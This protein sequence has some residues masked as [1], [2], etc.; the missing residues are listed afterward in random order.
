MIV[1]QRFYLIFQQLSLD[2]LEELRTIEPKRSETLLTV[3]QKIFS[4]DAQVEDCDFQYV[5]KKITE[6]RNK[7]KPSSVVSL[8]D[9]KYDLVNKMYSAQALVLKAKIEEERATFKN[10]TGHQIIASLTKLLSF[11]EPESRVDKTIEI[12]KEIILNIS[13]LKTLGFYEHDGE[14]FK[15]KLTNEELALFNHL[16]SECEKLQRSNNDQEVHELIVQLHHCMQCVEIGFNPQVIL[17][18]KLPKKINAFLFQQHAIY[19]I[20][21]FHSHVKYKLEEGLYVPYFPQEKRDASG[22]ITLMKMSEIANEA[23]KSNGNQWNILE[24]GFNRNCFFWEKLEPIAQMNKWMGGYALEL[25][26]YIPHNDICNMIAGDQHCAV[27]LID[28]NGYVF[29][30]GVSGDCG[31]GVSFLTSPDWMFFLP[32]PFK[33]EIV[34][35]YVLDESCFRNIKE[36][37]EQKQQIRLELL[38]LEKNK[39]EKK[40]R[41]NDAQNHLNDLTRK[42]NDIVSK[43]KDEDCGDTKEKIEEAKKQLNKALTNLNVAEI[44]LEQRLCNLQDD[45]LNDNIYFLLGNNCAN[46]VNSI[47]E[48]A[49]LSNETKKVNIAESELRG[50]QRTNIT[51][52]M[53]NAL[54]V[55]SVSF[56]LCVSIGL[57]LRKLFINKTYTT[58]VNR[59]LRNKNHRIILPADIALKST[60]DNV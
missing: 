20:K 46:F 2:E 47:L 29:S 27:R 45:Q 39:N 13:L 48:R 53:R 57:L 35:R 23:C 41:F 38:N 51:S 37:V 24:R 9:L 60:E 7:P 17:N 10:Q 18:E 14:F 8:R 22:K 54:R 42:L 55:S 58:I 43:K 28:N 32:Q 4:G 59:M 31:G 3:V 5:K 34:S 40:D 44:N 11:L 16:I 12:L 26:T 33:Q 15:F 56:Q 49:K 50:N 21:Y 36:S 30:L 52:M 25:C 6:M 19:Q 1:M